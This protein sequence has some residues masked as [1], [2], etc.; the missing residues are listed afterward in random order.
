MTKKKIIILGLII[1]AVA[2]YLIFYLATLTRFP[3]P[4]SDEG[5][6]ISNAY[7]LLKTGDN[8]TPIMYPFLRPDLARPFLPDLVLAGGLKAFGVSLFSGRLVVFFL[9]ILILILTFLIAQKFYN[10]R[11]GLLAIALFLLSPFVFETR[12]IRNDLALTILVLGTLFSLLKYFEKGKKLFVALA[13][14]LIVFAYDTH[15]NAAFFTVALTLVFLIF[16]GRKIW[17][18]KSVYFYFLGAILAALYYFFLHIYPNPENYFSTVKFSVVKDHPAPLFSASIFSL[19]M[20]EF[21]RYL[22][23]FYPLG[24]LEGV[25]FFLA[26]VVAIVRRK[27]EDL[28][29]LIFL[30]IPLIFLA[31]F[32]ANKSIRYLW[33]LWP[34]FMI[35]AAKMFADL[36][37]EKV[38]L[39]GRVFLVGIFVLF[40][41]FNLFYIARDFWRV[42]N[43][44][45]RLVTKKV[46]ETVPPG[47]KII[48]MP[49]YQ[50][51]LANKNYDF[52]SILVFGYYREK[53][54][55]KFREA[56]AMEKPSYLLYDEELERFIRESGL[57][58][59]KLT[60]FNGMY[61]FPP[62]EF[63]GFLNEK[64]KLISENNFPC[65]G[66]KIYQINW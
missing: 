19:L 50:I 14:F 38:K 54:K 59:E 24:I 6:Q 10:R 4:I 34:I 64:G 32:S 60:G 62:E 16:G 58:G 23:Y 7:N 55:K 44:D 43:C 18:D 17:R 21:K 29:L 1:V 52:K 13:G 41:F 53:E 25:F 36:F 35:L 22:F 27:K 3:A 45:Y 66:L 20:A 12:Y 37:R 63:W 28:F 11:V 51:D 39:S 42:K 48:A 57:P 47:A 2:G 49:R 26:L 5:W 31:L 15:Q 9:F 33:P 46:E 65:Y 56:M 40:L 30:L 61:F 8:S